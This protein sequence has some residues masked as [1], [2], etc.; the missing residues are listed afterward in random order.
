MKR[1]LQV[2]RALT[3][4]LPLLFL[5]AASLRH[6]QP[7]DPAVAF[8]AGE[9]V[10]G[11][12]ASFP[13]FAFDE[14]GES[15]GLDIDLGIALAREIGL[16]ARF[17]SISFNGLYDSLIAGK[18]DLLI[19]ALRV[20]PAR[21]DDVRYSQPYYN[22][23]LVLVSEASASLEPEALAGAP[24]AYEYASSADSQIRAWERAGMRIEKRPYELPAYAL[25]A[26][27][28]GQAEGALVDATSYRLYAKTQSDWRANVSFVTHD[29][30][31][32]AARL[33]PSDAWK[34]VDSALSALKA[35]GELARI[36][37]T[38]L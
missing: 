37:E 26:L 24:I 18:V 10:I 21:R 34:L 5:V 28:F 13:P 1:R 33:D 20:E 38:W 11:V 4:A 19:S 29:P 7:L 9:I 31:V 30:Y 6:Y 22:N 35:S 17:V 14:G 27:R 3:V 8:P 32:I 23:G 25:D 36:V 15:R 2:T 12:D 16:S